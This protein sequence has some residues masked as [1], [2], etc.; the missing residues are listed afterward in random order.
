[1]RPLQL[2]RR[3]ASLPQSEHALLNR[4]ILEPAVVRKLDTEPFSP[5]F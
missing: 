1:M 3:A 5:L 4:A 2:S